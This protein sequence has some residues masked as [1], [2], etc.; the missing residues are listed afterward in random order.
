V[1]FNTSHLIAPVAYAAIN[2]VTF[3]TFG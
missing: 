1:I 3:L 2:L